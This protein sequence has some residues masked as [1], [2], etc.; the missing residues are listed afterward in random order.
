VIVLGLVS[1]FNLSAV[2][3]PPFVLQRLKNVVINCL[4]LLTDIQR[5]RAEKLGWF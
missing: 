4:V 1:F 3:I 2:E 5:L